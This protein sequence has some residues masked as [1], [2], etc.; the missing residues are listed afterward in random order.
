MYYIYIYIRIERERL[1]SIP[2]V[3]VGDADP[4]QASAL[5]REDAEFLI[6]DLT[7]ISP[8]ILSEKPLSLKRCVN[9]CVYIYIYI[10]RGVK[11]NV[12]FRYNVLLK[13]QL[14]KL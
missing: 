4:L 1:A 3:D 14:A 11:S 13:L 5:L 9:M 6:W 7:K 10:A 8:T 2:E 12:L